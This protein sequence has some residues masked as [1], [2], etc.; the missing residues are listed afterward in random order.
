MITRS[1]SADLRGPLIAAIEDGVST[2]E[3]SRRFR[4][5]ISTAGSWHRRYRETVRWRQASRVSHR[6][7]NSDPHGDYIVGLIEAIGYDPE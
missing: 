7:R 4:I 1:L 2:Q 6:V 5:G 3:A